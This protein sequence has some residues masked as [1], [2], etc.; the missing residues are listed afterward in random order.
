[1]NLLD[2]NVLELPLHQQLAIKRVLTGDT[3][4]E[5]ADKTGISQEKV[6]SIEKGKSKIPRGSYFDVM[7][8]LYTSEGDNDAK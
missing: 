2:V 8:Y 4:Q 5:V 1:M 3:Q 7:R 6:S